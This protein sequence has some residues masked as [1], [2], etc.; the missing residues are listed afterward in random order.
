MGNQLLAHPTATDSLKNRPTNR[1]TPVRLSES[2]PNGKLLSHPSSYQPLKP[3]SVLDPRLRHPKPL[4]PSPLHRPLRQEIAQ[5]LYS[6][7]KDPY[8]QM[9]LLDSFLRESARAS[10]LDARK[11]PAAPL[12]PTYSLF[13]YQ[14]GNAYTSDHSVRPAQSDPALP[15]LERDLRS[16]RQPD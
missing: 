14:K 2:A 12:S 3:P 10:P 8:D 11:Q 1:S 5:A 4:P 9:P 16:R 15:V 13:S 6:L 7:H